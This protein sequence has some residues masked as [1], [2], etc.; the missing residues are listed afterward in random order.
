MYL[1]DGTMHYARA[2]DRMISDEKDINNAAEVVKYLKNTTFEG[3]HKF[4][5]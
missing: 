3:T 1:Y 4:S 5:F 2:I